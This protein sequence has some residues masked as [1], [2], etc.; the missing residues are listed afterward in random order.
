MLA[1]A[2]KRSGRPEAK[3]QAAS[4]SIL[5]DSRI[6]LKLLVEYFEG[7]ERIFRWFAGKIACSRGLMRS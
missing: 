2:A 7:I 6:R 3:M 5:S 1:A 4:C